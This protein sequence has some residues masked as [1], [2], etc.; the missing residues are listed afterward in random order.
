MPVFGDNEIDDL[1]DE[2][3]E[4]VVAAAAADIGYRYSHGHGFGHENDPMDESN[5]EIC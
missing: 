2:V 5:H 4:T 1:V 3:E